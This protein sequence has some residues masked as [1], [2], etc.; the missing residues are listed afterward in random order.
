MAAATAQIHSAATASRTAAENDSPIPKIEM[1]R[2]TTAVAGMR[3]GWIATAPA[4]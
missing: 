2:K 1:T 4:A 3:G